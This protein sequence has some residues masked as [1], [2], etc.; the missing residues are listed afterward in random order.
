VRGEEAEQF[1]LLIGQVQ[2]STVHLRRVARLVDDDSGCLDLGLLR[3]CGQPI[4]CEPDARIH[5]RG[6]GRLE[7]DIRDTPVAVDRREPALGDD[8]KK[9]NGHA[10]GDQNLAER[11]R[12]GEIASRVDEDQIARGRID[13]GRRLG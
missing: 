5:L 12:S 1:E 3:F 2:R 6:A 7:H 10:G 13:Q 8:Q 4:Q 9:R 11:L